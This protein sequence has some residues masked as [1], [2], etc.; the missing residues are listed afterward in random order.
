MKFVVFLLINLMLSCAYSGKSNF[1]LEGEKAE[2]D[3]INTIKKI[4]DCIKIS[5]Y[6]CIV[7][8][9]TE[10]DI[11]LDSEIKV[12][13]VDDKIIAIKECFS[14]QKLTFKSSESSNKM[15]ELNR[16]IYLAKYK[17]KINDYSALLTDNNGHTEI[18]LFY[19][20]DQKKWKIQSLNS[21]H[22]LSSI[23]K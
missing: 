10:N 3:L 19:S 17:F 13:G 14:P 2:I 5:N 6:E 22:I 16:G 7:K 12:S 11:Y 20:A 9:Y 8:N 4:Q 21:S 23:V 18:Q 15:I 1:L